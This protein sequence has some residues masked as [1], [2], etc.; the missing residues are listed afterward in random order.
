MYRINSSTFDN[1]LLAN[2][3]NAKEILLKKGIKT[4]KNKAIKE[5]CKNKIE[6]LE[7]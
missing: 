3:F 2:L 1:N 4:Y 7:V 5:Y 6:L